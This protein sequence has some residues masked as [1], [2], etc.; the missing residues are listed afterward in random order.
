MFASYGK[1]A[2]TYQKTLQNQCFS[3]IFGVIINGMRIKLLFILLLTFC[4]AFSQPAFQKTIGK[5]SQD[6][7]YAIKRTNDGGYIVSGLSNSYGGSNYLLLVKLD[8]I[9]DTS[10][11]KGY[12]TSNTVFGYSIQQTTDS[13]YIVAGSRGILKTDKNGNSLWG[14]Q[15]FAAD[16]YSV[17]QTSDGGYILVGSTGSSG[18]SNGMDLFLLK[19]DATGLKLWS[20]KLGG[21]LDEYGADIKQMPDGTFIVS[22]F[23]DSFGAGSWDVYLLKIKANGDTL[24]TKTYGGSSAE[25]GVNNDIKNTLLITSDGGFIIGANTKSFGAGLSDTYLLKT[26]SLGNLLWSKTYGGIKDDV[27]YDVKQT[28][29]GGYILAGQT[30]SF[31]VGTVNGYLI[32]TNSVGDTLWTRAFGGTLTNTSQ[33]VVQTNDKGYLVAGYT[34]SFGAGNNDI[35]LIKTD[36]LGNS[37]CNQSA[38]TTQVSS[39]ATITGTTATGTI[40]L[41]LI[42]NSLSAP[43]KG[44]AIIKDACVVAGIESYNSKNLALTIFPNPS[45][46][47]FTISLNEN[48]NSKIKISISDLLG[49]TIYSSALEN[50]LSVDLSCLP[51]G[52]YFLKTDSG[53]IS[54]QRIIINK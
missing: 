47:M 32:K 29:D 16:F 35:Y 41:T 31:G 37:T 30:I 38:T 2:A 27:L 26:D 45:S 9:G 5:F 50:N 4:A 24:W 36:S 52:I 14:N 46:G 13:G 34:N 51:N 17:Q 7:A 20:R 54:T 53:I 11:V 10:W 49:E 22:G 40:Y 6:Y 12:V 18:S 43:S 1:N 3:G 28:T 39:A 8:S 48:I 15:Y 23:T 19:L 42:I 44:G 33:G 21:A 25:G